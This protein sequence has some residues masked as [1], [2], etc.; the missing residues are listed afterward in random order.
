MIQF[1]KTAA[2]SSFIVVYS[3]RVNLIQ[4]LFHGQKLENT[5]SFF[6]SDYDS[7]LFFNG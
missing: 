4:L 7:I 3:K 5:R 1:L 6:F 2:F